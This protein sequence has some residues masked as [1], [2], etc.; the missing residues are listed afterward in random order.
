MRSFCIYNEKGGVGKTTVTCLE[1]GHLAYVLGKKVC[2]LDFDN[3][4]YHL[5]DIREHEKELLDEPSSSISSFL[6][7][8]PGIPSEYHILPVPASEGGYYRAADVIPFVLDIAG[9]GYDYIMYDFPGRFNQD[10]AVS[11][12][13]ANGLIDF[14]AIPMDRDIQSRRSA[15]IIANAMQ[16]S[17][18]KCC[19]FWNRVGK[20]PER[21]LS[22]MEDPFIKHD[23]PIMEHGIRESRMLPRD[24]HQRL[25]F[26]STLCFPSRYITLWS[27]SLIP[28]LEELTETINR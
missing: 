20:T 23:I 4:S 10:E 15:L 17:G 16:K 6:R 8:N 14:V 25:F 1:A 11:F 28:F 7:S 27:P 22:Y 12:L 21:N 19:V 3:P 26:R 24:S 2:V 5:C 18:V 13:A 9:M